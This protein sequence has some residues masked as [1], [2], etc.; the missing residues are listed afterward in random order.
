MKKKLCYILAA[1]GFLIVFFSATSSDGGA[2]LQYTVPPAII[3][4]VMAWAGIMQGRKIEQRE[5]HAR[6]TAAHRHSLK[7]I[8]QQEDERNESVL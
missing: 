4:C 5:R 6:C 2:G 3:G 1:L 8:K 7:L